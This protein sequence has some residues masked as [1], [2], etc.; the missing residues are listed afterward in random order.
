MSSNDPR[1]VALEAVSQILRQRLPFEDALKRGSIADARDRAFAHL[2]TNVLLR[3]KGQIDAILRHCLEKNPPPVIE[4]LLRLAV[5]QLLFLDIAPHAVVDQSVGLAKKLGLTPLA[6]LVNA[7]LR[8]ISM[9][10]AAWRDAQ[11]EERLN[12][13][14]WLWKSWCDA[15]GEP[16]TRRISRAHLAEPPLDLTPKNDPALWAERTGAL[17][18]F[19]GSLRLT[20]AG[21]VPG[22]PG[23]DQGGWWVQDF[24]ASLPVRLL[25]PQP[26]EQIADLCA[27]PGGKTAQLAAAGA[28]V[29]A[30]DRSERRLG[31]LTDNLTRLGLAAQKVVADAAAWH[32]GQLFDKILLDAPCSATGTLR[33]HPD[34]AWTKQPAD[35]AKL[36]ASQDR[37]LRAASVLLRPG[38][39]LLFCTCSLQPEEGAARVDGFLTAHPDF[40]RRPITAAELGD[41]VELLSSA[42]DLRSLPCHLEEIGGMDGFFA[43]RLEKRK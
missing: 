36:A 21:A 17:L 19:N 39:I 13:P 18:L 10:G 24:A 23:F 41:H 26:G 20:E 4:D 37:L 16:L 3:R 42:G 7:V 9:E 8:R 27:A 28:L 11:D 25:S 38:G 22:L 12:C 32:P 29:T 5:A 33:R 34:V 35:I 43:A 30:L 40:R 31:R 6:P 14:D 15:Y 1:A 2:L